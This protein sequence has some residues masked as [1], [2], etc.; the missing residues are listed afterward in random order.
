MTIPDYIS[1]LAELAPI[2]R[3]RYLESNADEVREGIYYREFTEDEI[4]SL[5]ITNAATDI[6]TR[7][8]EDELKRISEPIKERLKELR[9]D[10]KGLVTKLKEKR[11]EVDG[12]LF[13][14]NDIEARTSYE[15]DH[16]GNIINTK[17]ITKRQ[18]TIFQGNR[19]D[20]TNG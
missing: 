1:N 15:I 5:R 13:V 2:E 19:L 7:Q 18:A 8:R 14:F 20:G 12:M 11:E 3:Q 6:E 17:S 16:H 9:S 4:E 10:K